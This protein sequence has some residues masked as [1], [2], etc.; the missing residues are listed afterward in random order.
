MKYRTLGRSSLKVSPLCLGTMDF[1][2]ETDEDEAIRITHAAMDAGINFIDTA[3]V[4]NAG[5]SEEMVGRALAQDNRR[6]RVVLATK[7][8]NPMGDGPNRRGSS[9]YHIMR[10]CEDS[11]RRLRTDRIDLY[12]LHFMDLSTPPEESMRALEDL[13]RQGKV[14]Y[15]GCSKWTPG[16]M[17]E[18][19]AVC[20]RYGWPKLVS[21]QPPYNLCDRSIENELVWFCQRHGVGIIPW[22]PIAGGILSGKYSKEGKGPSGS[23]YDGFNR[24]LTPEAV[25]RAQKLQPL[26][27]EK[28]ASL[29]QYCLAWVMNQPGITAPITGIRKMEHLE[30]NLKAAEIEFT[31]EELKRIDEIA[32]PGTAVSD[33]Y[34]INTYAVFRKASGA[35]PAAETFP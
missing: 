24:R 7:V 3:N 19:M 18:A 2:D 29:A 22:A 30:A 14:L 15:T 6:D 23:R 16:W 25:E 28:G 33:Y 11:L 17:M 1:G 26:A 20:E 27:D 32:P 5:V 34:D 13:A 12:Q 10:Q 35:E 21:E 31:G 4:Y 9:R 8:S